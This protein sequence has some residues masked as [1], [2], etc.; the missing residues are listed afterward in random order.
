VLTAGKRTM[1]QSAMGVRPGL[2]VAV[3]RFE[4]TAKPPSDRPE[5]GPPNEI[6]LAIKEAYHRFKT[7]FLAYYYKSPR[8]V[9]FT[10]LGLSLLLGMWYFWDKFY[11]NL[12]FYEL[13]RLIEAGEVSSIEI[14]LINQKNGQSEQIAFSNLNDRVYRTEIIDFDRFREVYANSSKAVRVTLHNKSSSEARIQTLIEFCYV[15]FN[16]NLLYKLLKSRNSSISSEINSINSFMKSKAMKVSADQNITKKFKDV[17]G[18]DEAKLE[19]TEFVDFLK[20][21]KKYAALGAKIPKGALL[22]GPPGTGKTLLGKACAGEAGVPFFYASGSEFHEVFVGVGSSR[23]R[24][25]FDMARKASPC[26]IFIDEIDAI[27]K[28]RSEKIS[29]NSEADSTLNQLL[30]EMDGFETNKGIVVFGATNRK[31]ILDPAILRPGRLDRMVEINT[32]DLRARKDVFMVHLAKLTFDLSHA[33]KKDIMEVQAK[34]L[35]SLTPGFSGA[36]IE[37]ICNEA[38][39][40]AVRAKDTAV[41]ENHFEAAVERIIGGVERKKF[42]D[43][44]MKKTVAIHESGHGVVA[45]FLPGADPLLKLTIIPRSKGSLGFAQYLPKESSLET[46]EE[47]TD[48]IT[49]ILAGRCAEKVFFGKVTT[50]AYDDFQKAYKIAY[51]MVTRLGMSNLGLISLEIN[52][53]GVKP[54]S[55]KTNTIIDDECKRIID[56]CTQKCM[57]MVETHRDKIEELSN[58]L[59]AQETITLKDII[60]VLGTRP[61]PVNESFKAVLEHSK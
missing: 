38:A 10:L 19:I 7:E 33:T 6:I 9:Q 27:A 56:E 2:V 57:E 4:Q 54:Y 44:M 43:Q 22:Y 34:R 41:R 29:S 40:Q 30:V 53:F 14:V 5:R 11:P 36:D 25:L 47:L 52:Q 18:M 32:P 26:I 55:N 17:A 31:D 16:L 45:W 60:E 21:P 8:K 61:F 51:N 12:G 1:G 48:K 39:I 50:G 49:A 37:N 46:K 13:L 28:K 24:D 42:G 59:L 3:R 20:Q 23:I 35:A 15:V 58:V